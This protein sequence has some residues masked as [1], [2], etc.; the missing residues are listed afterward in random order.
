[1]A[2]FLD[3]V[4]AD[5]YARYGNELSHCCLV[6]PNRRSRLFFAQSLSK[7]I[8]RPLWQPNYRSIEEVIEVLSGQRTSDTFTLLLELYEVYTRILQSDETFDRFYFWGDVML[9]DFDLIDKYLINAEALFKNLKAQKELEGDLSFLS[10]EQIAYIRQFWSSFSPQESELQRRFITVWE[11]LWPIY[12]QYRQ[13]LSEKGMAY[14]GM[15]YREAAT[16]PLPEKLHC[17]HF[18]FIG[19]NAL[20][21]CEKALFRQLKQLGKAD[22]YWDY[23]VYY[24][25]N[26]RQEAGL[27]LRRNIAE[28][29]SP[30]PAE[31]FANFQQAK[32]IHIIAA[33]SEAKLTPQLVRGMAAPADRRTA[34]VLADEQLLIPTLHALPAVAND[35]NVTMGYPLKQTP[36]YALIELLLRLHQKAKTTQQHTRF[37]YHDVLP[38]LQHPYIKAIS[39]NASQRYADDMVK[40]NKV[41]VSPED[42]AENPA[43]AAIFT[44]AGN[45]TELYQR[46][47]TLLDNIANAPPD[48]ENEKM[49]HAYVLHCSRQL[50]KLKKA[51]DE[52][53][54]SL[55][56]QVFS[57][58]LYKLFAHESIPFTGEPLSGLQVL[59]ILETRN[60]D[61]ENVILL[62]ANEGVLPQSFNVPSFIP[63][64]L[65]RGFGLPAIEQHEA[66]FAYYFYRLLQ[67]AKKIILVY[68]TK[69]DEART[70]EA[71]R[72]LAQ[73]LMESGHTVR[74]S[75]VSFRINI[76]ETAPITVQKDEA[77]MRELYK[78]IVE[79][80]ELRVENEKHSSLITHHSS[81]S[82][83]GGSK[84]KPVPS[85][86]KGTQ[87]HH[88]Q[89]ITHHSSLS[90]SALNAYIAC[91]MRFYFR[92]IARL[93]R[94]DRRCRRPVVRQP[95]APRHGNALYTF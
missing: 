14:E 85:E 84:A 95:A 66:V 67:R 54:V 35:I 58:M 15:L 94:N 22:F 93:K 11:A 50:N 24:L 73:L 53:N 78:Y 16:A 63:Y 80:G 10:E 61:F 39:G 87:T 76:Q 49:V 5:L 72:Y 43:L 81:P 36:V 42:F 29:P 38:L 13:Q 59:G 65:R 56:L 51:I 9:H 88:S 52:S 89:L 77:V 45:H 55:S 75:S 31:G 20:N 26:D 48:S 3:L 86:A 46:L 8:T 64:N 44:P 12:S 47:S 32:E 60:L 17:E 79:S 21:E 40:N 82:L 69:T 41:Y 91:P 19:F 7:L 62:S 34:V 23:D 2:S 90:P 30:L 6:F 28:F 83:R 18:V 74:E 33:P 68:N 71:S 70:G 1:M 92:Y 57:N 4:A 27:F 37:Y 25:N